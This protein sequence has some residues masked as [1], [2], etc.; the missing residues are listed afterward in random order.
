M[1]YEKI[2][3]TSSHHRKN[4]NMISNLSLFWMS[5]VSPKKKM[6]VKKWHFPQVADEAAKAAKEM[7]MKHNL[8]QASVDFF[9][10]LKINGRLGME[11]LLQT[12]N[13]R[14]RLG[15]RFVWGWRLKTMKRP[16]FETNTKLYF[17][18]L[19]I[20]RYKD[21]TQVLM[22]FLTIIVP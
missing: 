16:M 7:A 5:Q 2:I 9:L 22:G 1:L 20:L 18:S 4:N 19:K 15:C 21:F 10:C 3:T 12:T 14:P 8:S 11:K 13:L 17:F 6:Y